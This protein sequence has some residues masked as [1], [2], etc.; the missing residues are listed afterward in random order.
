M[1][2]QGGRMEILQKLSPTFSQSQGR[3]QLNQLLSPA[4]EYGY[5]YAY[6]QTAPNL[7]QVSS[8]KVFPEIFEPDANGITVRYKKSL[9]KKKNS[10]IIKRPQ[11]S[12]Y[13]K[14]PITP[15]KTELSLSGA[16]SGRIDRNGYNMQTR[17]KF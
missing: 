17:F 13:Q 9:I 14:K 4:S 8:P 5:G 2:L 1:T 11:S 6:E 3:F 15:H 7:T 16:G 12:G 10:M